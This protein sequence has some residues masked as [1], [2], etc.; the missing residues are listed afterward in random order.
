MRS[1]LNRSH[2]T[3]CSPP[4]TRCSFSWVNLNKQHVLYCYTI[5]FLWKSV[6]IWITPWINSVRLSLESTMKAQTVGVKC[7]PHPH[8]IIWLNFFIEHIVRIS[9]KYEVSF[10]AGRISE[11]KSHRGSDPPHSS[12]LRSVFF[13]WH[14]VCFLFGG[15]F[16]LLASYGG[17]PDMSL[18][19]G[20]PPAL[21]AHARCASLP[22]TACSFWSLLAG[23]L[24]WSMAGSLVESL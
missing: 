24:F 2:S 21:T 22:W 16:L 17:G 7:S 10:P 4:A 12:P 20:F 5:H 6:I 1:L 19:G 11:S 18:N 3:R 14:L 13:C 15:M 9:V 23:L 8:H